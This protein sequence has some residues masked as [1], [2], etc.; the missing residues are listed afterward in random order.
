[1]RFV[2]C[3][4]FV[5]SASGLNAQS[6]ASDTSSR[7]HISSIGLSIEANSFHPFFIPVTP[8]V[9]Y[10]APGNTA[11]VLDS[12][13]TGG[14]NYHTASTIKI[15]VSSDIGTTGFFQ[16][17]FSLAHTGRTSGLYTSVFQE[18]SYPIDTLVSKASGKYIVLDSTIVKKSVGDY[19]FKQIR[20]ESGVRV[21][22][23]ANK[24]FRF[25][26]GLNAGA[27]LNYAAI[28]ELFY[29]EYTIVSRFD[30][31][32]YFMSV[33]PVHSHPFTNESKVR[34]KAGYN[35]WFRLPVRVS[36]QLGK[37]NSDKQNISLFTEISGGGT[38]INVPEIG[39]F[40]TTIYAFQVGV[41]YTPGKKSS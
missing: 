14:W 30:S 35:L 34:N 11:F 13:A 24:R 2:F 16:W 41:L 17:S 29:S 10:L 19:S 22:S 9:N 12:G 39:W 26:T 1:M 4:F 25:S 20:F 38:A 33:T 5:C 15:E 23:K 8:F 6:S 18:S 31:S 3:L 28:T 40:R 7:F 36:L 37:L 21:L 27:S 32:N